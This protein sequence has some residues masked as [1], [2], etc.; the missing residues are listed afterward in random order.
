MIARQPE[1]SRIKAARTVTDYHKVIS[2]NKNVLVICGNMGHMS[3]PAYRIA[4]ELKKQYK[5]VKFYDIE[6]DNPESRVIRDLPEVGEL[7]NIPFMVFYKSGKV[8][9]VTSDIHSKAQVRGMLNAEF[10][11]TIIV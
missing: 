9:K 11:K 10:T 1:S 7:I 4:E 6:F 8:V 5:H 3:I 2:E